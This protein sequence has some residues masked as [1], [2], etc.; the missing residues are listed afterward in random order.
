MNGKKR[1]LVIDDEPDFASIVQTNLKNEGF[2]VDVAYDGVEGLEKIKANPPDVIVL[3]TRL[4]I[5]L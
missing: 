1:I 3:Q 4:S 5:A 2:D